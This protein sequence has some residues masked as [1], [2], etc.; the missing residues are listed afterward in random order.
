MGP[1]FYLMYVTLDFPLC[2]F[3]TQHGEQWNENACT[4]C[5]CDKGEVRCHK[6]ACPP[7]RCEKVFERVW[8]G[9]QSFILGHLRNAFFSPVCLLRE[10]KFFWYSEILDKNMKDLFS[11]KEGWGREELA[12]A[13]LGWAVGGKEQHTVLAFYVLL[14]HG[15]RCFRTLLRTA[16]YPPSLFL[17]GQSRAQRPGECCEECVSPAGSCSHNGIVRYQDEMWKGSACEFCMCDHGQ[18][19]CQTGECAKV[20]CAQVRSQGISTRT[21][22]SSLQWDRWSLTCTLFSGSSRG[23]SQV[24]HSHFTEPSSTKILWCKINVTICSDWLGTAP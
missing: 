13:G 7:L 16:L 23:D 8:L 21:V 12:S 24:D 15:F 1:C 22:S 18:V 20:E 3:F 11:R 4:T 19:I 9:F 14:P 10:L 17:Q 6:E 2:P 5:I